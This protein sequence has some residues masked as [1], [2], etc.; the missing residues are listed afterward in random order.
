MLAL[1]AVS[2]VHYASYIIAPEK[3]TDAYVSP[4]H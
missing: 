4:M 3:H 1:C 2:L